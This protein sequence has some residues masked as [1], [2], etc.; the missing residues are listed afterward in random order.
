MADCLLSHFVEPRSVYFD[1]KVKI[2]LFNYADLNRI[3]EHFPRWRRLLWKTVGVKVVALPVEPEQ[4][5]D[6]SDARS[7]VAV[8]HQAISLIL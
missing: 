4:M 6:R 5:F 7:E 3:E 2:G 8:T 1:E